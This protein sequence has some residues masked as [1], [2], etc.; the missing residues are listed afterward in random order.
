MRQ[1]FNKLPLAD[2]FD[3]FSIDLQSRIVNYIDGSFVISMSRIILEHVSLH[4]RREKICSK[5][6]I[7]VSLKIILG[8]SQREKLPRVRYTKRDGIATIISNP[9]LTSKSKTVLQVASTAR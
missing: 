1:N 9:R 4:T 6:S 3:L 7:Q 8:S 2:N 5:F